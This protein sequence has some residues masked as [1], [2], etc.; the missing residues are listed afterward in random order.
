MSG[1]TTGSLMRSDVWI[2]VTG[3]PTVLK[4]YGAART[5]IHLSKNLQLINLSSMKKHL[6]KIDQNYRFDVVV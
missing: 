5:A 2:P 4:V 3:I 1:Y 6:K